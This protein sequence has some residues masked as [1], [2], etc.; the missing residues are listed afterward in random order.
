[1]KECVASIITEAKADRA[2]ASG[3][4]AQLT[5]MDRQNKVYGMLQRLGRESGLVLL[6]RT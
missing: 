5:V 1:M 6:S 2:D 4:R 3:L